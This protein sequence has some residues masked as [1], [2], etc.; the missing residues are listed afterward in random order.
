VTAAVTG[1]LNELTPGDV[2]GAAVGGAITG[3]LIGACGPACGIAAGSFAAAVGGAAGNLAGQGIDIALG[4]QEGFDPASLVVEVGTSAVFGALPFGKGAAGGA[5]NL[6]RGVSSEGAEAAAKRGARASASKLLRGVAKSPSPGGKVP[7]AVPWRASLKGAGKPAGGG[8]PS[9]GKA[10][11][12]SGIAPIAVPAGKSAAGS[13]LKDSADEIALDFGLAVGQ[14]LIQDVLE[15]K[16]EASG[17]ASPGAPRDT[18][19][20]RQSG[21]LELNFG[22]KSVYGEHAAWRFYQAVHTL[23]GRALPNN[24]NPAFPSF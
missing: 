7:I 19:T 16:I 4:L 18:H 24:P 13:A 20:V 17:P 9:L 21:N 8:L 22:Q 1:S 2:I 11:G 6:A 12:P 14:N 10:A 23:A 15:D 3:G 5:R